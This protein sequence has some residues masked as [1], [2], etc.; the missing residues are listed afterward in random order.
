MPNTRRANALFG[1]GWLALAVVFAEQLA[2]GATGVQAATGVVAVIVNAAVGVR[3]LWRAARR[4]DIRHDKDEA[5]GG[6]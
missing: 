6:S 3:F 2:D 5:E 1:L 4:P